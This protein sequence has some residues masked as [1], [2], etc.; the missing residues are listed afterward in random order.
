MN[1]THFPHFNH[2][3]IV[4]ALELGGTKTVVAIGTPSG[5]VIEEWRFPTTTPEETLRQAVDWWRMRGMPK[6]IGIGSFGP[7]RLN[8]TSDAEVC[9]LNTPKQAW[10]HFPLGSCLREAAP[11]CTFHWET[12]VNAAVLAEVSL[13]AA[14][15][16]S[17]AVYLTIGTGIGGGVWSQQ[18]LLH[19]NLHPE[20]G[21]LRVTRHPSDS[22]AGTCPFHGD[23]WEGLASGPAI[24]AR[25]RQR[26]QDLPDNHPAWQLESYYLA[27]GIYS[28]Q[29][30]LA[31]DAFILGG[32]VSQAPSLID[33]INHELELLNNGYF[34]PTAPRVA[35]AALDQQA[36]IIG[37]LLL[38][39]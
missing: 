17:H 35:R 39:R 37:C 21:H 30:V 4:G 10:Q 11:D 36:G 18:R 22:F 13:G 20:I 12:D 19:G 38:C 2:D 25:W 9:L 23:C 8:A 28:L 32:G 1:P 14:L 16:S 24:E 3:Q 26:A 5:Q 31:A 29:A 6:R 7:I 15:G 33:L 27:Q 34:E